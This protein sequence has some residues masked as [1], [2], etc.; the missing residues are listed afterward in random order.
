LLYPVI[1]L[2]VSFKSTPKGVVFSFLF[3]FL[4]ILLAQLRLSTDFPALP[5]AFLTI[6]RMSILIGSLQSSQKAVVLAFG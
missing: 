3:L 4:I 1:V 6:G 5:Q 2:G